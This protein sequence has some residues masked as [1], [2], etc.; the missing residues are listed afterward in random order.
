MNKIFI[1]PGLLRHCNINKSLS[2]LIAFERAQN[3]QVMGSEACG[4]WAKI[5]PVESN[6]NGESEAN[7][8]FSMLHRN[9]CKFTKIVSIGLK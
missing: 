6:R 9:V 3:C 1:F 7:P 8:A 4:G 2:D 5:C